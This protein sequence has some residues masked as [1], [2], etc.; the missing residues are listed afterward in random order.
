[1][2]ESGGGSRFLSLSEPDFLFDIHNLRAAGAT[3]KMPISMGEL[4]LAAFRIQCK[5]SARRDNLK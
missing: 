1:M 2:L 3:Q 5:P 4:L